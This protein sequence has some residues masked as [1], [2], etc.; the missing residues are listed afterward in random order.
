MVVF[1]SFYRS[2]DH[3]SSARISGSLVNHFGVDCGGSPRFFGDF[4]GDGRKDSV[5]R[6]AAGDLAVTLAT[7]TGFSNPTAWASWG[8]YISGV[9][10]FNNDGRDDIVFFDSFWGKTYVGLSDGLDFG[11]IASWG[12]VAGNSPTYPWP[13]Y[14]CR[15]DGAAISKVADFTGD[16]KADLL[17]Y[18]P[19]DSSRQFVS[20]SSG[21]NFVT[22][23]FAETDCPVYVSGSA[24]TNAD[25]REDLFCMSTNGDVRPLIS[26]GNQLTDTPV[27]SGFCS[28]NEYSFGDWN[29]DGTTDAACA[30]NLRAGLQTGRYFAVLEA[31]APA[32]YCVTGQRLAADLD[33]D[34]AADWICNNPGTPTNDIEVR[35]W[36]GLAFGPV[37]T[38]RGGFCGGMLKASDFN[39]DGKQDLLCESTGAVIFAGT[40][41]Q[42]ADILTSIGNGIGATT[43]LNWA[44]STAVA[45]NIDG[46]PSTLG[47]PPKYLIASIGANDGRTGTRTT[48]FLYRAGA[49][50]D[51]ERKFFGFGR[52]VEFLPNNPGETDSLRVIRIFKTDKLLAGRLEA[53]SRWSVGVSTRILSNT[54]Y[55][56]V[57]SETTG[58]GA[59][60]TA[61]LDSVEEEK[62]D[63][64]TSAACT[65]WSPCANGRRTRAEYA[66]DVY[67]NL[68]VAKNLG[69]VD[70]TGDEVTTVNFYSVNTS[71]YLVGLLG[72]SNQYD[73][74]DPPNLLTSFVNVYDGAPWWT[75][76]PVKGDRTMFASWVN[77]GPGRYVPSWAAYDSYGNMI[78]STDPTNKQT[79]A[80]YE[81]N[82]N[83]FP[84]SASNG[85]GE[86][87][88]T[89]WDYVCGV[90]A[91]TTDPNGVTATFA[92]DALCRPTTT[93]LPSPYGTV[94]TRSYPSLGSPGTQKVR[95][96]TP[97]PDGTPDWSES[98]FDGFGRTWRTFRR[99]PSA[100]QSILVDFDYDLRGNLRAKT[101][102]Y[103]ANETP[104]IT[105]FEFDGFDRRTKTT[106][107]DGSFRLTAFP[108]LSEGYFRVVETN[109]LNQ[110]SASKFDALGQL[111]KSEKTTAQGDIVT[112]RT[113]DLL[114]R[115]VELKD[116][117]DNT[118]SYT[119]DS[120]GRLMSKSDP[121]AGASTYTYDDAARVLSQKDAKLQTTTFEYDTVGRLQ[122]RKIRPTGGPTGA[123]T[124]YVETTY[125]TS[126]AAHDK[127]RVTQVTTRNSGGVEQ[128]GKLVFEYDALGRATKQTRTIDG[129]NY[130]VEKNFDTAGYL[131]GMKY[132][133]NDILGQFGGSGSALGYDG[134]GR[135]S[136]IPGIL[137][138]VTY[139]AFGAPLVQTNANGTTTTKTYDPNRF[140]LTDIDTTAPSLVLQN[141]H[142]T[143]N[144]AGMVTAVDSDISNEDWTYSYD[145]LNRL[146]SSTNGAAG[147]D[148]TW[149][150]DSLGRFTSN[151]RVGTT[152]TYPGT[153]A[154]RPH[155]PT[156]ISGGPLGSL[157]FSYDGNGNLASG[158]SRSYTWNA[159]NQITQVIANSATTTFTYGP[160]GDRI[161]KA[162]G[163]VVAKYPFGDD[164]EIDASGTVTKYFNAGF[165]PIAKKVGTTLYWLHTDRLG[166]INASTDAGGAQVLRRSYR[167]YGGLLAQTGTAAVSEFA[168]VGNPG[169][170]K[171]VT[172]NRTGRYV[173]IQLP[174][175]NYLHMAE[176]QVWS[177]GVNVALGKAA[178][179]S[180]TWAPG[181]GVAGVA[182][183][184]ST[185][186]GVTHTL[187][188]LEPWWDVDLGAEYLIS[189]VTVWN[190]TDCCQ[191]R[192]SDFSV[193]VSNTPFT[194]TSMAITRLSSSESL[195]YIGQ[196]TDSETGLTYLHARYYDSVLGVFL[197]PDPIGADMNTYRYGGGDPVNRLD[198]T[199]LE[200]RYMCTGHETKSEVGRDG[201]EYPVPGDCNK[202]TWVWFEP[203]GQD[204]NN[205]GQRKD[206][207]D[208]HPGSPRCDR[209]KK[210]TDPPPPPPPDCEPGDPTCD[211]DPC[212]QD[213]D[214]CKGGTPVFQDGT[215]VTAQAPPVT[216]SLQFGGEAG[217]SGFIFGLGG[218]TGGCWT[219]STG[220]R[221][222]VA[223]NRASVNPWLYASI[224]GS[225]T[226]SDGH[227]AGR[228][229]GVTVNLVFGTV[230]RTG[231][232]WSIGYGPTWPPVWIWGHADVN[233]VIGSCN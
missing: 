149:A 103:Y 128:S 229:H 3:V 177:S 79:L 25:G 173:R 219:P 105:T 94:E 125:G 43:T 84:T 111:R 205:P 230:T 60:R 194:S 225:V 72:A 99:G 117:Q 142:Y 179:Q 140:W 104:K 115:L 102:P 208:K 68:T 52:V 21:T 77:E 110:S 9:G 35:R 170:S 153:G 181:V 41:N 222:V 10:D 82:Y 218:Y 33:G 88:F 231:N 108:A 141:L 42:K 12:T 190:R 40:K 189:S 114:G 122:Y 161:K 51:S 109:E 227:T 87:M 226:Y 228:S 49:Q 202:W 151:S 207:C 32:A 97:G 17:C 178:T 157:T 123:V 233:T 98:Y 221:G 146:T 118:W 4:N 187:L 39:G 152:F 20:V 47:L 162:S 145:E 23:V 154:A 174:G 5:C 180:S 206:F 220:G 83:V 66:Y 197:S 167:A 127:G 139:N 185:G 160:D 2:I 113:Y 172:V 129:V 126:A 182:V 158:N 58:P 119:Y 168:T 14:A 214:S 36:V 13:A 199:G 29:G 63:G 34:G 184:G 186:P 232:S 30:N 75:T 133:D 54:K 101:A 67:G 92:T 48:S 217:F 28:I 192:L 65:T 16:G 144:N 132:P 203:Q 96:E 195:G 183:D 57:T 107:P 37:Q 61:L 138:S 191:D 85:A 210:P 80:G 93:A 112:T 89:S 135:L 106:L 213:P 164:Y 70:V 212:V 124:E 73:A 215:T 163:A 196:R 56:Y 159:N 45:Q 201:N 27:L 137:S 44:T 100:A 11:A 38:W 116:P 131:R 7:S 169:T 81:T 130:V 53:V 200:W 19:T 55:H 136:T 26:L 71:D 78:A 224:G 193:F 64:T 147:N 171:Q 204:P 148:Q 175:T 166:S 150:Y 198:P 120:L 74:T 211:P 95:V 91:T 90:P 216:L 156:S 31:Q 86:T 24:D 176:V 8:Q 1:A 46:S 18:V 134:A 76:P 143:P 121:D 209:D 188:N 62:Y 59:R 69:D 155:A 50:D 223:T 22:Y 165:G 6:T 15:F